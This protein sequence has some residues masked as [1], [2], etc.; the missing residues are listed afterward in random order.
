MG[1]KDIFPM[2]QKQTM[3]LMC[4][5]QVERSVL[6]VGS[7]RIISMLMVFDFLIYAKN[8]MKPLIYGNKK[9]VNLFLFLLAMM[10][11]K[12]VAARQEKKYLWFRSII[13]NNLYKK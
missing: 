11:M 7:M 8:V 3:S 6:V 5:Q 12:Q 2:A 4:Q 10:L 13:L 9:M 1:T